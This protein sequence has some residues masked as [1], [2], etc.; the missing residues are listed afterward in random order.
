M[1]LRDEERP[2]QGE[3]L[4][5]AGITPAHPGALFLSLF[6]EPQTIDVA[7]A[8]E[9]M[10]VDVSM[11]RRFTEQDLDVTEPLAEHLAGFTGTSA[12][13]WLNLQAAADLAQT[14]DR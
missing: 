13:F 12:L 2:L 14:W 11:L 3:A 7:S 4:L 10:G 9:S 8:A 5:R 1:N 6:L